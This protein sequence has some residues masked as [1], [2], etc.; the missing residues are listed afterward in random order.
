M[1][2]RIASQRPI[3]VFDSGVGGLTVLRALRR[4]FPG[5]SF[6]YLGDTARLPYGTKSAATVQRYALNAARHLEEHGVRLLVV[7]CNTAS[8]YALPELAAASS[9]PVVGVVEPGVRAALALGVRRIGVL[10]TEGTIRSGSYQSTLAALD[11]R[12]EVRAAA[13]PLFVPLAEEGWGDHPVTDQVARHYL[14]PLLRWRVQ[15]LILG[16]THYPLLRPSLERVAGPDVHLVDSASAVAD[17]VAA[18]FG[19]TE[20]AGSGEVHIHLTD[21][22]DH[23]LRVARMI[24]EAPPGHLEVVTLPQA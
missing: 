3:G 21:A 7:A 14:A 16:C 12:P 4:R 2:V 24:L 19:D 23:F 20:S 18:S 22:S 13:C 1:N 11:G 5:E 17:A 8:S 10:G 6:L 15:A 9:V